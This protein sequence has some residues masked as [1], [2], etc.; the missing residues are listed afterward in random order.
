MIGLHA[1]LIQVSMRNASQSLDRA[2]VFL[3][4]DPLCPCR[5]G[6]FGLLAGF[7]FFDC[8]QDQRNQAG[9]RIVTILL[10]RAK[11]FGLDDQVA[12]FSD[13]VAGNRPQAESDLV[14][15]GVGCINVEAQ[16]HAGR[17]FIDV[18][19]AGAGRADKVVPELIFVDGNGRRNLDHGVS[20][21]KAIVR[22]IKKPENFSGLI[23]P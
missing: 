19:P 11:P 9:E 3:F 23:R 1:G 8:P 2:A 6:R 10:L 20:I 5:C 18:L 21:A 13:A 14:R 16:L 22:P 4:F 17:D 7:W 12:V 15:Q